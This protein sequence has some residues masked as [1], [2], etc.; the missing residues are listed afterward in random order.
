VFDLHFLSEVL[1]GGDRACGAPLAAALS[2]V[3]AKL[4]PVDEAIFVPEITAR[5]QRACA[6]SALLLGS[7]SRSVIKTA[8]VAAG[9]RCVRRP[10]VCGCGLMRGGGAVRASSWLRRRRRAS[11][12]CRLPRLP[13]PVR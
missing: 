11:R 3:R 13:A 12:R 6:Q 10:C 5:V 9:A 8:Q 4:D 1:A 7:L 2:A